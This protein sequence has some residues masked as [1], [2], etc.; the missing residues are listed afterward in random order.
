MAFL[1]RQFSHAF[2][3]TSAKARFLTFHGPAGFD[4]FIVAAGSATSPPHDWT[5]ANHLPPDPAALAQLAATY[6]I[7]IL[8]PSPLP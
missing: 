4:G 3:V 6:G 5:T 2:V 8:G 1:P 7:E